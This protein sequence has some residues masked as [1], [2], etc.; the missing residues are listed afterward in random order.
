VSPAVE[1]EWETTVLPVWEWAPALRPER[2]A[3]PIERTRER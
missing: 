2:Y 1:K 3:G